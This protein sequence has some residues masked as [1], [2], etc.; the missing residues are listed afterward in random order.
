MSAFLDAGCRWPRSLTQRI[1]AVV[2]GFVLVL[3]GCTEGD[4]VSPGELRRVGLGLALDPSFSMSAAQI[5]DARAT[6]IMGSDT[7]GPKYADSVAAT[8]DPIRARFDFPLPLPARVDYALI[9]L[10]SASGE[11]EYSARSAAFAVD[12]TGVATVPNVQA[13]PG[14]LEYLDLTAITIQGRSELME[15]DTAHL[16]VEA[17]GI[18]IRA[19]WRSLDESVA[20]VDA[21]G[22]VTTLRP[23]TARIEAAAGRVTDTVTLNIGAKL[24]RL[25][26]APGAVTLHS[27]GEVGS[28]G[29]RA[30]NSLN[31]EVPA[32]AVTWSIEPA[33]VAE[34]TAPGQFRARAN[35]RATVTARTADGALQAS[36]ELIVEQRAAVVVVTPG[37]AAIQEIGGTADFSARATDANGNEIPNTTFTW[38]SD[39]VNVATI[40]ASGRATAV[41][42][43]TTL[44]RATAHGISGQADLTVPNPVGRGSIRGLIQS[45]TTGGPLS[46]ATV[47]LFQGATM[48]GSVVTSSSGAYEFTELLPGEYHLSAQA[49]GYIETDRSIQVGDDDEVIVNLVLSPTI[50]SGQFRIVLTWGSTPEDLDSYLFGPEDGGCSVIYYGCDSSIHASLDVDDTDGFGPETVTITHLLTNGEYEY[51]VHDYTNGGMPGSTALSQSGA[52]VEVYGSNGKIAEYSVPSGIGTRWVVFRIVEG[53]VVPVNT[54]DELPPINYTRPATTID[55]Q[56][57]KKPARGAVMRNQVR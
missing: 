41:A 52:R 13:Y 22:L 28:Y 46:G 20:Q 44:I 21:N 33:T 32:P 25:E 56:T 16:R 43:G 26:L 3:S 7:I 48:V 24:T 30:F 35:G 11:V 27:F 4:A 54:L 19:H 53:S 1:L 36:G 37:F 47:T 57:L 5:V 17:A 6:L 31:E 15:G 34:M 29:V 14:P 49:S 18:A 8:S 50:A 55:S 45:A 2:A 9:E 23:G 10:L 40:D 12:G 38:T 51:M 39:N 42:P